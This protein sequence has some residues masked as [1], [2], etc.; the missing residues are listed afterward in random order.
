M[1][2]DPRDAFTE[3]HQRHHVLVITHEPLRQN[4][5]GPGVRALEIGRGRRGASRRDGGHPVRTG[6]AEDSVLPCRIFVRS[7]RKV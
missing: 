6:I 1:S 3:L 5:S 4:L 7:P 2:S